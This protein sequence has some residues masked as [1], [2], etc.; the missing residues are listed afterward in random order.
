MSNK[1]SA[2]ILIRM[3]KCS[4]MDQYGQK[5]LVNN[6]VTF[7]V[8]ENYNTSTNAKAPLIRSLKSKR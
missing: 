7:A 3:V 4:K 1:Y 8:A 2:L 6:I 5:R